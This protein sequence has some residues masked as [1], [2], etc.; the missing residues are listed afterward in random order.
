L[1][2]DNVT[3]FQAGGL[4]PTVGPPLFNQFGGSISNGFSL[5]LTHTNTSGTIFY[6]LNG[7]DPRVYGSGALSPAAQS[8][9]API[10]LNTTTFVRARVLSGGQWSALVETTFFPPQDLSKL[11]LTELMYHPPDIGA[12]SG[13]NL[14]FLELKNYGTNT[15]N[16]SGL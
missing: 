1:T 13:N 10:V 7:S 2:A 4:Y 15:L 9:S 8:Y 14:E 11:C 12:T 5:V 3:R 16:L 6:T